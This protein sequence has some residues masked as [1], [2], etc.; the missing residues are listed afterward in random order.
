ML[1]PSMSASEL[2]MMPSESL[3][4][5]AQTVGVW[6]G[7]AADEGAVVMAASMIENSN[8]KMT[9]IADQ[10]TQRL[11]GLLGSGTKARELR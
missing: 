1:S 4:I 10:R 3:S 11:T 7:V 2:F 6:V 5:G 8:A 9:I